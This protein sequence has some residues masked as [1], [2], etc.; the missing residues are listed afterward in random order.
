M[1]RF[2]AT[3]IS[4]DITLYSPYSSFDQLFSP[5][6]HLHFAYISRDY[7]PDEKA[8]MCRSDTAR[9]GLD[10][11]VI[12]AYSCGCVMRD[13][14]RY[15]SIER[16]EKLELFRTFSRGWRQLIH[17]WGNT[18]TRLYQRYL[19]EGLYGHTRIH[20]KTGDRQG[21]SK[22]LPIFPRDLIFIDF[23]EIGV[24]KHSRCLCLVR[25]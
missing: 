7:E 16:E 6:H 4:S 17:M 22:N 15:I 10:A 23:D 21:T 18:S 25:A 5:A 13:G 20:F 1:L 8:Q 2:D 24:D 11:T 19:T 14:K 3:S 9:T 12:R